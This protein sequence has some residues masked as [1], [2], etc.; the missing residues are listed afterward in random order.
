MHKEEALLLLFA[1]EV[2]LMLPTIQVSDGSQYTHLQ[3]GQFV[4][5]PSNFA[6]TLQTTSQTPA[7][8]L[9]FKWHGSAKKKKSELSFGHFSMFQPVKDSEIKYGFTPRLVFEGPT[10]YLQ[11]LHCHTSTLM[12]GA[13]YKPHSDMYDVAIVILEGE[14]ETLGERAGP[15]SVIFYAAGKPHGM[16]NP[17]TA[18]AKYIV[19]EFHTR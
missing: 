17:G 5:Y 19:F 15:Y 1:G 13:G 12:P 14:V 2:D 4:Y 3:A 8:Y 10:A 16:Q 7:N 11:K 18:A 9:I 6:H